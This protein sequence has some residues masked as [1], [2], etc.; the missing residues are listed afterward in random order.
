MS[1]NYSTHA[2]PNNDSDLDHSRLKSS[3]SYDED[4]GIF[5][6]LV[7]PGAFVKLGLFNTKEEAAAA[8]RGAS[9]AHFREFSP[10]NGECDE[11][12][13]SI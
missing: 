3:L 13:P 8:Y 9:I 6:W 7:R 11:Q 12:P 5:R 1:L 2:M 4:T 10:F